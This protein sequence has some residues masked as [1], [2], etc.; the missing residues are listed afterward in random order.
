MIKRVMTL[1]EVR[2]AGLDALL[3]R[4]GAAGTIR[5]L[6]QYD[7]GHGDYTKDRAAWL[8][9]QPLEKIVDR[10][11]KARNAGAEGT[12]DSTE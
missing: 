4:L 11:T 2:R 8:D 12:R 5:F 6:Q 10:I 3:E 9:D 7:S 1:P